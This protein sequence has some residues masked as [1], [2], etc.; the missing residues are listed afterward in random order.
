MSSFFRRW[1]RLLWDFP[2]NWEKYGWK[3]EDMSDLY[4]SGDKQ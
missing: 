4:L 1:Y 3:K 2:R